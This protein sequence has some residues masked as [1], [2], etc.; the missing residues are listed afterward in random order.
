MIQRSPNH[1]RGRTP[2]ALSS[3]GRVSVVCSNSAIRVSRHSS[4]PKKNGE[5]APIAIWIPA[6][7]CAAFQCAPNNA[8][9]TSWCSCTLV[10]AASGAIVSARIA[11]RSTP[12]MLIERSS[13]RAAKICSLSSL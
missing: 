10:H 7:A 11:K 12:E 6:I 8:G 4:R 3:S 1:T 5:F 13:P 9:S 2:W